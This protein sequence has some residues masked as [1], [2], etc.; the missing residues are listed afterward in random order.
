VRP[1]QAIV[2]GLVVALLFSGCATL[3]APRAGDPP[4]HDLQPAVMTL[5]LQ[6]QVVLA[7]VHTADSPFDRAERAAAMLDQAIALEPDSAMLH[8]YLAEAWASKLDHERAIVAAT[9]AVSLDPTDAQAHHLLGAE[10]HLAGLPALAETHLREAARRGIGGDTPA[11]PHHRLVRVL[12]QTG[13]ADAALAAFD[14]WTEALPQD[15]RPT[16]LKA[17]YQWELGRAA[18]ARES[19][20]AALLLDPRSTEAATILAEYHRYDPAGEAEAL[21]PAVDRHWSARALHQRLSEVYRSM[22]RFDRALD[23]LR[24]VGMLDQSGGDLLRG[25]ADLLSRMHRHEEAVA[26]LQGVLDSQDDPTLRLALSRALQSSGDDEAAL[27][28]LERIG[29]EEPLYWRAAWRRSRILLDRGEGDRA[30]EAALAARQLIPLED[31]NGRAALLGVVIEAEIEAGEVDQ[32]DRLLEELRRSDDDQ[33][34]RLRTM[35]LRERGELLAAID[36][37]QGAVEQAPTQLEHR[38]DLA[39]LQAEAGELE[40]AL[41]TFD[42]G[43]EVVAVWRE[44]RLAETTPEHAWAI[45]EKAL[46]DSARLLY[47]RSFIEKDAG[48]GEAAETSLRRTLELTPRD[49]DALNALAYLLAEEDRSLEEAEQLILQALDMRPFSA[50]FQDTLGWVRFRQGRLDEALE[51]LITADSW[52]GGDPEIGAHVQEVQQALEHRTEGP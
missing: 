13:Q 7:E 34:H 32:V 15:P 48:M 21:A 14:A 40:R 38:I 51:L 46:R 20:A 1:P 30:G 23:H 4:T 16:S 26:L 31:Y 28:Q 22:G 50:A 6:S 11:K 35:A 12:Q 2:G 19:A 45:G 3:R 17:A 8:R 9:R 29:P 39:G 18:D 33:A 24:Y 27:G 41:A 10:L 44:V 47:R 49:A 36:L 37:E 5:F 43:L 25:R 42:V 52:M